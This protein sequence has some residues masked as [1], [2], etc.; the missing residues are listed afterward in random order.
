M[1][2]IVLAIGLVALCA[3]QQARAIEPEPNWSAR[4]DELKQIEIA[5][6]KSPKVGDRITLER[7][8]GGDVFGKITAIT[9]ATVTL[10]G[11]QFSASQL[12]PDT[13]DRIFAGVHATRIATE[14]VQSER[15]DYNA[16]RLAEL[17]KQ[18]EDA[19]R[20]E[21]ERKAAEVAAILK[22]EE[23][24]RLEEERARAVAEA[25]P[26]EQT[27]QGKAITIQ[28]KTSLVVLARRTVPGREIQ[29]ISLHSWHHP[30]DLPVASV[31]FDPFRLTDEKYEFTTVVALNHNW[32]HRWD[33]N[34]L[35]RVLA[36]ETC[37]YL[38]TDSRRD[39]IKHRFTYLGRTIFLP[40]AK[41][42]TH[43]EIAVIL[44]MFEDGKALDIDNKV[45]KDVFS[46]NNNGI[47]KYTKDG[48]VF[49]EIS[50]H[51]DIAGGTETFKLI[52]DKLVYENMSR[53]IS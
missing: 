41:E 5:A 30:N 9:D 15:S 38:E 1:R 32:Q 27:P 44:R 34:K 3:F 33:T 8:V 18:R 29:S 31:I 42:N 13:C 10:D 4:L 19:Q 39:E 7:R 48:A 36:P 47:R 28:E 14:R 20:L 2:E 17:Q 24:R 22:I 21:A 50:W 45:V 12:T 40:V 46:G 37:W 35:T 43:E 53:W 6:F 52:G 26:V 49:V 11:S 25:I 16:R 23:Q 51:L